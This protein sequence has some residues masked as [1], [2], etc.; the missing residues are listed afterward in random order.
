MALITSRLKR[1]IRAAPDVEVATKTAESCFVSA[2][3]AFKAR[4]QSS[5]K[6][7][8]SGAL[9][10]IYCDTDGCWGDLDKR[11]SGLLSFQDM[12]H[13]AGGRD[14]ARRLLLMQYCHIVSVAE[15]AASGTEFSLHTL[16]FIPFIHPPSP[17]CI[18]RIWRRGPHSS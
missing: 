10:A 17:T 15:Q 3:R 14:E 8:A 18:R 6:G 1:F 11:A 2:M 7:P 9:P 4:F 13:S 5:L 12:M 16:T